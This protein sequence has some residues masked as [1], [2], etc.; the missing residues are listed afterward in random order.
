MS[1][2]PEI[3]PENF[4]VP[5]SNFGVLDD[6]LVFDDDPVF[7]DSLSFEDGLA[8]DDEIAFEGDDP[9]FDDGFGALRGK[10]S[11]NNHRAQE[12][13]MYPGV[14]DEDIYNDYMAQR[15]ASEGLG[16]E[17]KLDPDQ[18]RLA[19]LFYFTR[20]GIDNWYNYDT[21]A[22]GA[23]KG[24]VSSIA[25][26][27]GLPETGIGKALKEGDRKGLFELKVAQVSKKVEAINDARLLNAGV[28]AWEKA[29]SVSPE[30]VE[31][32]EKYF[33]RYMLMNIIN[34]RREV[35]HERRVLGLK[36][37]HF[38]DIED[39]PD[40]NALEEHLDWLW[41]QQRKQLRDLGVN[42]RV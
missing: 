23:Q 17:I 24:I 26:D 8:F 31:V 32:V 14:S 16:E 38:E 2:F 6:D 33:K 34:V 40:L 30:D 1:R 20:L 22:K 39:Y 37:F 19:T 10:P 21:G 7:D 29:K 35:N 15:S 36:P 12:F 41:E 18:T 27:T 25:L 5:E 42:T 11:R 9:V 3:L 4:G 28:E 13:T